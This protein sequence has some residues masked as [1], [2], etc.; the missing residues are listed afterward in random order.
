MEIPR[1]ANHFEELNPCHETLNAIMK[2]ACG[3]TVNSSIQM[4]RDHYSSCNE[5]IIHSKVH[6][7][8]N[9]K[10]KRRKKTIQKH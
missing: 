2:E 10:G 5:R 7:T 6:T 8:C 4:H 1:E 9:L 3:N